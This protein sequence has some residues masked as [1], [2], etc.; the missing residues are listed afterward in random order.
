[1]TALLFINL[2]RKNI[3]IFYLYLYIF[4]PIE[5]LITFAFFKKHEPI[6]PKYSICQ[7]INM[8]LE[9][10]KLRIQKQRYNKDSNKS[11]NV[12][13]GY[14]RKS[15]KL[16]NVEQQFTKDFFGRIIPKSIDN[17]N[18]KNFD[19]NKIFIKPNSKVWVKFHEGYSNA[20]KKPI[21]IEDILK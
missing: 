19:R 11:L 1:M 16:F 9:N 14:K 7:I 2:N 4:S 3:I 15:D 17:K 13:S 8:E 21:P 20:I 10:E 12:T 6:F 5:T 18:Q